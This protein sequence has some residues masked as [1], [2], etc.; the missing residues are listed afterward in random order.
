M[1]NNKYINIYKPR[2]RF[3]NEYVFSLKRVLEYYFWDGDQGNKY[4]RF[5]KNLNKQNG[6]NNAIKSQFM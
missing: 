3:I 2:R 5:K 6:F 4:M 1:N